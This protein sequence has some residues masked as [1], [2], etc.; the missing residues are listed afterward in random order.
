ME[1][2]QAQMQSGIGTS[3]A[4]YM[5]QPNQK[6]PF[7][8]QTNSI[9]GYSNFTDPASGETYKIPKMSS[10]TTLSPA[11]Q[12]ILNRQNT[13]RI[14]TGNAAIK[15]TG[16]L[17]SILGAPQSVPNL[18][19]MSSG[20][21]MLEAGA[22]PQLTRMGAGPEL[23]KSISNAGKIATG[24]GNA[25]AIATGF[26]NAGNITKTYGANDFS[27]DRTKVEQALM[28]RMNP[29][30]EQ[31]RSRLTT[32]LSNQ[33][34]K[35]GTEAYDRAM[36]LQ[37]QQ[38]N[39]ANMQAILAGGQEQSRLTGL[40]AGKAQFQ[41]SAQQ[42]SY[43]QLAGRAGFQNAAQAQ[44]YGQLANRAG[45]QNQ[46]Q[47]QQF[48]QNATQAQFGNT[49]RQQ[50]FD[51]AATRLGFNNDAGQQMW[52]NQ[53][54]RANQVNAARQGEFN[55]GLSQQGFNNNAAM[56]QFGAGQQLR[57][58]SVN[59]ANALTNGGQ[60][61]QPQFAPQQ[62]GQLPNVDMGGLMNNQYQGQMA[63]YQNQMQGRNQM[64]GGLF[65]LGAAAIPL[66]SDERTKENIEPLGGEFAGNPVYAYEY[67]HDPGTRHIGVMAQD[68]AKSHPE[69][70]VPMGKFLGV[71]YGKLAAVA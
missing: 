55:N 13:A 2:A 68:V 51:N 18:G 21:N 47:A 15:A 26:G 41:N 17:G 46:A 62:G 42:Q 57:S 19:R 24:F 53:F 40:E 11:Q 31:E 20:Q 6:T 38:A 10:Q 64:M 44:N 29:A 5:M 36:Q 59:N 27:A 25:G 71:N 7:G 67:K 63:N 1:V 43:D 16:Q 52:D 22:G 45:F 4:N 9:T 33:G 14:N 69:A 34:I 32:Q 28:S 8:S 3:I 39:D 60:V 23:N 65:G 56:Q 35:Q 37:G 49:A 50:M 54:D 30:L 61:Q 70:V 48:G 66:L 58:N 12:Q